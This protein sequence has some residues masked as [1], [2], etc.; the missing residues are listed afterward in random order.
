[1]DPTSNATTSAAQQA[2]FKPAE[3]CALARISRAALY[4]MPAEMKPASIKF[5]RARIIIESPHTWLA[6][7]ARMQEA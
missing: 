4:S 1:M 2:G 5:G 3:F 6:R 7:I